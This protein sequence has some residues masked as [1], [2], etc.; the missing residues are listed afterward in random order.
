M[1]S[2][3]VRDYL[4]QMQC[5]KRII[6][7]GLKGL[8]EIWEEIVGQIEA[9]YKLGLDD[10]LN[11]MDTRQLL[12]DAMMLATVEQKK[13]FLA[14]VRQADERML[15]LVEPVEKC[16]WGRELAEEEGWD[17]EENWWYYVKPRRA[18]AELLEEIAAVDEE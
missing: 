16:L 11:D 6:R 2:D 4:E 5:S 18:N 1:A 10:Y 3:P 7:G 8:V 14:R 17:E 15:K 13:P 9:G 12:H